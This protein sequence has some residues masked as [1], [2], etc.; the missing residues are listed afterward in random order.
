MLD[1]QVV[2][3]SRTCRSSTGPQTMGAVASQ[4]WHTRSMGI[5]AIVRDADRVAQRLDNRVLKLDQP[6][7]AERYRRAVRRWWISPTAMA[8]VGTAGYVFTDAGPGLLIGGLASTAY[9]AG[10]FRAEHERLN[11]APAPFFLRRRPRECDPHREKP[12]I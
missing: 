12:D 5:I 9:M 1:L 8:V 7:T 2:K 11:G 6:L 3:A 10:Y 4:R